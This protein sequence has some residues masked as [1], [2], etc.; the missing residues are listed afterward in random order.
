MFMSI[1]KMSIYTNCLLSFLQIFSSSIRV[2]IFAIASTKYVP[3]RF[4]LNSLNRKMIMK[5]W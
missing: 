4:F 1:L 2:L 3:D 5:F